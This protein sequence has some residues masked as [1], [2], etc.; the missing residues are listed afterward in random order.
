MK[1]YC[2]LRENI[3][4]LCEWA[5]IP[6]NM[7]SRLFI[8]CALLA[9]GG[10]PGD[11]LIVDWDDLE[12]NIASEVN[13]KRFES[14]E[15]QVTTAH[16]QKTL[17]VLMDRSL[18]QEGHVVPRL[19]CHRQLQEEDDDAG[20]NSNADDK[21]RSQAEALLLRRRV[22]KA[23]R[24]RWGAMLS[25]APARAVASSLLKRRT[26]VGSDCA[27]PLSHDVEEDFWHSGVRP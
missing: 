19:P 9:G 11:L 2:Y 15:V 13:V 1:C 24:L 7:L 8:G 18:K 16:G 26:A 27:T 21:P 5:K 20:G 22:D 4:F 25:C 10:W 14:Q 17:H 23:W 3:G 12:K 6:Y